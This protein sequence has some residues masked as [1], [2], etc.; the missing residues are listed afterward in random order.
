MLEELTGLCS[1]VNLIL[2]FFTCLFNITFHFLSFFLFFFF[3]FVFL[4]LHSWHIEFPRLG[5]KSEIQLPGYATATTMQDPSHI[6]D[7]HSSRQRRI[8]NPLSKARYRTCN[9]MVPMLIHFHCT[10]ME[11]PHSIFQWTL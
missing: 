1:I 8:L 4:G 5:I 9:L 10:T 2:Y 6:C 7:L 3:F 11:I